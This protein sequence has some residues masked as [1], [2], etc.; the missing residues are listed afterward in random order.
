VRDGTALACAEMLRGG[1]TCF[2]DMYFFPEAALEAA[3]E[4]QMRVAVGLIVV[5]FATPYASDPDDY[6]RKGLALRDASREQPLASFCL[7][8]HAPYTVSDRTF[9][10]L[11]TLAEE[12]DIPCICTCTRQKAKSS[13]RLPTMACGRS[14]GC[15]ASGCSGRADCGS[16]RPPASRRDRDPCPPRLLGRALPFVESQAGQRFRARSLRC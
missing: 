15:A 14:S 1:V 10:R 5:D 12:L 8:P 13:A 7:A 11:A 9:A 6:L 16:W 3:L 2:N 4:A